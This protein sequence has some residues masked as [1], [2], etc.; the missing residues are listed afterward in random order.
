MNSRVQTR[1]RAYSSQLPK[2]PHMLYGRRSTRYQPVRTP[3][4]RAVGAAVPG[5]RADGS[6]VQ[7]RG[8]SAAP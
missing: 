4:N 2:R 7:A 3:L 5:P 6:R 8:N 1:G